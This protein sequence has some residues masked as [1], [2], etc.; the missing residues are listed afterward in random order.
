MDFGGRSRRMKAGTIRRTRAAAL[1]QGSS[2][3]W[4]RAIRQRCL[5][6]ENGHAAL[7]LGA[8]RGYQNDSS[9]K[10]PAFT[11]DSDL[12]GGPTSTE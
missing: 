2:A 1:R 7:R 6:T 8:I 4:T 12:Q 5:S 10:R 9:S 3:S 11:V